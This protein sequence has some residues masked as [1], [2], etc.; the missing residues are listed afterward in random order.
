MKLQTYLTFV[1]NIC[2]NFVTYVIFWRYPVRTWRW[3]W[4]HIHRCWLLPW[5][6]RLSARGVLY[7]LRHCLSR[8]P[9]KFVPGESRQIQVIISLAQ[10]LA[11]GGTAPAQDWAAF[12]STVWVCVDWRADWPDTFRCGMWST[13]LVLPPLSPTHLSRQVSVRPASVRVRPAPITTCPEPISSCCSCSYVATSP[14]METQEGRRS[15]SSTTL[16]IVHA[17]FDSFPAKFGAC[18]RQN[19]SKNVIFDQT[20]FRQANVG[21]TGSLA[22]IKEIYEGC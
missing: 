5:Q 16:G 20:E 22:S 15:S 12:S 3:R 14:R 8:S 6:H 11:A 18:P 7:L 17:C 10:T 1:T 9:F 2:Q 21:S 4:A 13:Y 19:N